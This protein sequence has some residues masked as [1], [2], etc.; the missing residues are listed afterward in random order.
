MTAAFILYLTFCPIEVVKPNAQCWTMRTACTIEACADL[1][2]S[3][4]F[5]MQRCLIAN[6]QSFCS[7]GQEK[8]RLAGVLMAPEKQR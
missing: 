2:R 8:V 7:D 3:K 4:D 6:G 1:M 5:G